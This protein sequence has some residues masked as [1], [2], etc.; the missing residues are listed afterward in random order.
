MA[1][2]LTIEPLSLTVGQPLR[3]AVYDNI[4][5]AIRSG[6]YPLGA[7]LPSDAEFSA[8]LGV[9]RTVVR[10]ALLL[11]EEDHLIRTK[12]GVG[13]FVTDALPTIG[14]ERLR[15][16]EE[17]LRTLDG[18]IT[19]HTL[20]HGVQAASDFVAQGLGVPERASTLARE[21][22]LRRDGTPLCFSF[23][24]TLSVEQL[25]SVSPALAEAIDAASET[26]GTLLSVVLRSLAGSA[27]S[28]AFEVSA[29]VPG[30]TRGRH[31]ALAPG[32]PT[33]TVAHTV[34]AHGQPIYIAKHTFSP[35]AG[36]L[37]VVQSVAGTSD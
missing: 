34:R 1:H 3:I 30:E 11:L 18:D 16:L 32:T 24:S 5:A 35:E 27:L 37:T 23:E 22:I 2:L 17:L 21:S 14:M 33:L 4:A 15:S 7:P 12:R 25:H 6:R 13:R 28:G 20:L 9:S 36:P 8:A 31:L 29:G 26:P 10:E 19:V